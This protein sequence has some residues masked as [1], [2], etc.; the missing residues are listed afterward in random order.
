M[1]ALDQSLSFVLAPGETTTP[2]SSLH[3]RLNII[4]VIIHI[5]SVSVSLS[6]SIFSFFRLFTHND[7]RFIHTNIHIYIHIK[8]LLPVQNN[9]NSNE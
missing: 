2:P 1:H 5:L 4:S 6:F 3:I 7:D 8:H 9:D